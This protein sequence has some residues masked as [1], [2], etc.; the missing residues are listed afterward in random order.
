[1]E[2]QLI[3][4]RLE[5]NAA[6]FAGLCRDIP[7][8]QARWKPTP[9]KWSILEVVNHLADEEV[10]DF[11]TRVELTLHH[12]GKAWPAID[13]PAWAVERKYNESELG[14]TLARFLE[15]RSRSVTW[16][17]ALVDPDWDR[18]YEHPVFGSIAAGRVM[19]SWLAHDHIH[20]RQINRLQRE[21]LVSE[22]SEYSTDYA[23]DW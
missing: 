16:L 12:P 9:E 11:R 1:M 2:I 3:I 14:V 7:E 21:Y 6:V 23:G 4:R 8:R 18:A 10:E 5:A 19:T 15:E 20:I 22:L 13:P 17:E